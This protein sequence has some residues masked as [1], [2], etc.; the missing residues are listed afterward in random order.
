MHGLGSAVTLHGRVTAPRL[1]DNSSDQ[2]HPMPASLKELGQILLEEWLRIPPTAAQKLHETIPQHNYVINWRSCLVIPKQADIS[3][4]AK[5]LI[6]DLC[7]GPDKRLGKGGTEEL[8][9][10]KF[11]SSID[12][13]LGLRQQKAPYSPDIRYPTDTSNFDPID[14]DRLRNSSSSSDSNGS[15]RF[16]MGNKQG[17]EHGFFEFTF[18]RFFDD[19]GR[20]YSDNCDDDG[21]GQADPCT[22]E[23]LTAMADT[24]HER[25]KSIFSKY[26]FNAQVWRIAPN[27]NIRLEFSIL[28]NTVEIELI[29]V[30]ARVT[31][32]HSVVTTVKAL[33]IHLQGYCYL[34]IC[35]ATAKVIFKRNSQAASIQTML[36]IGKSIFSL[37]LTLQIL[38]IDK[39]LHG[40]EAPPFVRD[41]EGFVDLKRINGHEAFWSSSDPL[42]ASER[43]AQEQLVHRANKKS[44]FCSALSKKSPADFKLKT[45]T[46]HSLFSGL[47]RSSRAFL[48]TF[49]N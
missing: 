19:G 36:H 42:K 24:C 39:F 17:N 15:N 41:V 16:D 2:M 23:I 14:P 31:W 44:L 33:L 10:H 13:E 12:F 48:R 35:L 5:L 28:L 38:I 26:S 9:N 37:T 40:F 32:V 49:K 7:C 8:K 18:R 27:R 29:N 20:P 34:P 6:L 21:Q 11:F 47:F 45:T 43:E 22:N 30:P 1:F 46:I 4:A 3:Q 25:S